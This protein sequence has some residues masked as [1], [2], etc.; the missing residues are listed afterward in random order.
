MNHYSSKCAHL[1]VPT[2]DILSIQI[3]TKK[4]TIFS[5]KKASQNFKI[6]PKNTYERDKYKSAKNKFERKKCFITPGKACTNIFY[7]MV[8]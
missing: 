8:K 3:N 1:R 4:R 6:V 5:L 2:V 7:T